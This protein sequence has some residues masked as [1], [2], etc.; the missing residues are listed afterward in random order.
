VLLGG[1]LAARLLRQREL[2]VAVLP[3]LRLVR[4]PLLGFSPLL[5][6]ARGEPA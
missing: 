5:R 2:P 1:S 6:A 4:A 3:D